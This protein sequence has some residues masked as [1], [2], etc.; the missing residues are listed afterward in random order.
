MTT[1]Q[2]QELARVGAEARLRAISDERQAL[3][4]AFPD[5][6]DGARSSRSASTA[7]APSRARRSH[8]RT[9]M[10]P[11]QRKAVGERMTAY[12][13]KRRAEKAGTA[14]SQA[15]SAS[16]A[17]PGGAKRRS[18]RK[19]GMSAEARR[20]QGERMRAY[21]AARRAQKQGGSVKRTGRK[22]GG[23]K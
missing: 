7:T 2:L 20:A 12:W 14:S 6:G 18:K 19:G 16:D 15:G 4:Q 8:K 9:G 3:L 21:W 13:A 5:L 17:S 11:A 1:V 10:S 23:K 22:T